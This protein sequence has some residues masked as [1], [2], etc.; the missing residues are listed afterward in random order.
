MLQVPI[1]A[2]YIRIFLAYLLE[3]A[4]FLHPFLAY[5]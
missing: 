5:T 2:G 4:R 1:Q 3:Y